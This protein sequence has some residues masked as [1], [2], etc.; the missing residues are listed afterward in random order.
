MVIIGL[1]GTLARGRAAAHPATDNAFPQ[2]G[3]ANVTDLQAPSDGT[4]RLV[5]VERA[6]TIR[7][8]ANDPTTAA[9]TTFL[10]LSGSVNTSG[11]GGLLGLAFHP[12]YAQ[13]G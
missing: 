4:N 3:F 12:D 5:A 9:R 13:N 11:E 6:G 2:L 10:D 1:T 7:V 8:F